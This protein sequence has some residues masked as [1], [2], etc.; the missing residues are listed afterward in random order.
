VSSPLLTRLFGRPVTWR[1]LYDAELVVLRALLPVA[2]LVLLAC[3]GA[4]ALARLAEALG[5]A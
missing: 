2:G 3:V 4:A 1:E 5:R